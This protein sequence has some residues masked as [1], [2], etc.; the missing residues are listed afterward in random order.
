MYDKK[1]FW[2]VVLVFISFIIVNSTF[3]FGV[4]SSDSQNTSEWKMD[5]RTLNGSRYYPGSVPGDLSSLEVKIYAASGNT[6]DPVVEDGFLYFV[7]LRYPLIKVNASNVSQLIDQSADNNFFQFPVASVAGDY[8]YPAAENGRVYQYNKTNLSQQI[9]VNTNSNA[10]HYSSP[11]VYNDYLYLSDWHGTSGSYIYQVNASNVT[12][13][14]NRYSKGA[15]E[16]AP[17]IADDYIY[18][19]CSTSLI[20]LN[21]T[22]VSI[23]IASFNGGG[24]DSTGN[25]PIIYGDYVYY[26]DASGMVYQLNKTN[27]S[28][29][30]AN[31]STGG[32]VSRQGAAAHG[33]VYFGSAGNYTYQLN[34]TNISQ[35]IANYSTGSIGGVSVTNEHLLVSGTGSLFQLNAFNISKY[36]SNY[37]TS[38]GTP[39]VVDGIVYFGTGNNIYQLGGDLP[40]ASLNSPVDNFQPSSL[41]SNVTFNC[42]GFDASAVENISF[43]ITDNDSSNFA[44]NQTTNLSGQSDSANWTLE[45]EG[46]TYIWAC[47]VSDDEGNLDW[48]AN[49]TI[50]QDSAA[51]SITV[52]SPSNNTF[53]GDTALDVTYTVTDNNLD[54]C[55]YSNDSMSENIT[56]ANC[57]DITD[58]IWSA[59]E[60]NVTI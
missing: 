39:V 5:G 23:F 32:I 8:V 6:D 18:Y 53:T 27:V 2:I 15:C 34:S 1:G 26:G 29:N 58:I 13:Y 4:L 36:V 3:V 40:T 45:I 49:R 42:S 47:L 28:L 33:Y 16:G 54:S 52:D 35:Q 57:A 11:I 43:Y 10:Q 7:P 20:Q 25:G 46:G 14:I 50:L 30:V 56:Q 22:N 55:W 51:P 17:V 19:Q 44:L 12:G 9:A 31:F 21:A 41:V 59:G 24:A 48:S 38:G 37:S 60:H